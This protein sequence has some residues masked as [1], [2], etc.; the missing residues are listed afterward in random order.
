MND[1]TVSIVTYMSLPHTRLCIKALLA[2][3]GVEWEAVLTSNGLPRVA[4]YFLTLAQQFPKRFRVV[5]NRTNEGFIAPNVKALALTTTPFFL[6]LNDDTQI[7]WDGLSKMLDIFANNSK[8]AL[9]GATGGCSELGADYVGRHGPT[10]EYVEG[11]CLMCRTALVKEHGLF[12]PAI[13][14][15]Y[16]EDSDL[17]LRMRQLGYTIHAVDMDVKHVGG[18]TS[19]F[20]PEVHEHF[21]TNHTYL[22]GKWAMYLQTRKFDPVTPTVAAPTPHV[23]IVEPPAPV[24]EPAIQEPAAPK[25]F[26]ITALTCACNR[27]E[28]WGFSEL[29]MRRQTLQPVQWIVL[30]DDDPKSVCTQ[31]QEYVHNPRWAGTSS[32]VNKLR[33]ALERDMIKG[34]AL[35]FW[36]NDDWYAP[37]WLEVMAAHLERGAIVGE[38]KSM[39]YNVRGRWW[40]QHMNMWHASLCETMVRRDVFPDLLQMCKDNSDA[41]IDCRLWPTLAGTG[42][43]P[44]P[45]C[46]R[47]PYVMV[48]PDMTGRRL[49]VGIKAM[50]GKVGYGLG[51][52]IAC[53]SNGHEDPT[54][55]K[56]VEAIGKEDASRYERFYNPRVEA[57]GHPQ[58]GRRPRGRPFA[59]PGQ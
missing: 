33:Y 31:S 37:T 18:A 47:V 8:A 57:I 20:T 41:Y 43:Q 50:P 12:D 27:P 52:Q 7:P 39:Y 6:M 51:H 28:A 15:A 10:L 42:N 32:L 25:T 13:K 24:S 29:Y 55:A 3:E 56:L 5:E 34:D 54:G 4:G 23:Q 48:D 30:D 1:V 40:M 45:N 14:F 36:E 16:G 46:K 44:P 53:L 58:T 9:V 38:G 59:K 19:R 35:M 21:A 17:S 11:S 2:S 26:K 49:S 22:R